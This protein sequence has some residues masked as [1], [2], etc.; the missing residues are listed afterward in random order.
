MKPIDHQA[1]AATWERYR[2]NPMRHFTAITRHTERRAMAEL[3]DKGYPRLAMSFSQPLALIGLKPLRLTD[4]ASQLGISKQLCLQQLKPIEEAGYIKRTAVPN[5][6]RAKYVQLTE[7]GKRLT[8]DGLLQLKI[9]NGEYAEMIGERPMAK[10]GQA[11]FEVALA[12][13]TPGMQAMREI[14]GQHI[15]VTTFIGALTRRLHDKLMRLS[16]AKGHH[17]LQMSFSQVLSLIDLKGTSVSDLAAINGVTNQA[18]FRIVRELEEAGYITRFA[19]DGG[20][21]RAKKIGL[22]AK[23]LGLISDSV[24]A[25]DQIE[26]EICEILGPKRFQQLLQR[27]Q[28]IYQGLGL[29]HDLLGAYEPTIAEQVLAGQS[30]S[31]TS[32]SPSLPEL[33]LFVSALYEQSGGGQPSLTEQKNGQNSLRFRTAASKMLTDTSIKLVNIEEQLQARLGMEKLEQLR[34]IINTLRHSS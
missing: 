1:L 10:L 13:E 28:K 25:M 24:A 5:D 3:S 31:P 21:R 34:G 22:T 30:P 19:E 7:N 11:M 14:R 18:I 20:D 4:I 8:R 12:L 23:G 9:I 16:I 32:I 2:D 26:H 17:R 27:T 33:L 15:M 6:R 29:E